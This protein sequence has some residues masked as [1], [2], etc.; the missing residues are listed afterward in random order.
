MSAK[1]AFEYLCEHY[2]LAGRSGRIASAGILLILGLARL[3]LWSTVSEIATGRS[4]SFYGVAMT[5]CGVALLATTPMRLRLIG[6]IAAAVSAIL[7]SGM[8]W[9]IGV[10]STSLL[11][12]LLPASILF[13]ESFTSRVDV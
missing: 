10:I 1:N 4:M 2:S 8:A 3:G 6:R 5:T 12:L 7:L 11:M 9:D 13:T